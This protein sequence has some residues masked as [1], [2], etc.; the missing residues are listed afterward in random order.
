M[1]NTGSIGLY[2]TGATS[3]FTNS[4]AT[5]N[6]V[7]IL[8]WPI[9]EKINTTLTKTDGSNTTISAELTSMLSTYYSTLSHSPFCATGATPCFFV[10]SG[11]SQE[12]AFGCNYDGDEVSGN[13]LYE[14]TYLENVG[15][16][17][18]SGYTHQSKFSGNRNTSFRFFL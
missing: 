13:T 2:F 15:N 3:V 9:S 6:P 7:D 12:I 5:V 14:G 8:P 4:S 18:S 16:T 1:V 11:T 17:L 10:T